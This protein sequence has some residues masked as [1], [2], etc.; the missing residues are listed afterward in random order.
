M[1]REQSDWLVIGI[2]FVLTYTLSLFLPYTPF[3][4]HAIKMFIVNLLW[5]GV[6][7][8]LAASE[9]RR[10]DE[11]TKQRAIRLSITNAGRA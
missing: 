3:F 6:V 2:G 4:V 7:M 8:G 11:E 10:F 1:T 5:W 9:G